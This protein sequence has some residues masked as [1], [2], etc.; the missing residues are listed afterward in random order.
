[1]N[2][3]F[4]PKINIGGTGISQVS[5]EET[6]QLFDQWIERKE[7]KKGMCNPRKLCSMGT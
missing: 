1:M 4:A 6:M 2:Q 5:L 3:T 7:K